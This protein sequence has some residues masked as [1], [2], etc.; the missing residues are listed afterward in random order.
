MHLPDS[1]LIHAHIH[2]AS[3][4]ALSGHS[5]KLRRTQTSYASACTAAA[6]AVGALL[7]AGSNRLF[8]LAVCT[9]TLRAASRPC[10]PPSLVASFAAILAG[11]WTPLCPCRHVAATT[12]TDSAAAKPVACAPV[13]GTT[14]VKLGPSLRRCGG[15]PED[16]GGGSRPGGGRGGGE[17]VKRRRRVA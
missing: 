14:A 13:E 16:A 9:A 4:K 8:L 1:T 17:A 10:R 3:H 12:L 11:R 15:R 6:T 5:H 7:A 2:V